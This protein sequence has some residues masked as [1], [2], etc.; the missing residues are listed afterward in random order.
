MENLIQGDCLDNVGRLWGDSIDT[1]ITSPPYDNLR[2]YNDNSV[3]GSDVWVPLIKDLYRVTRPGGVVVWIVADATIKGS[4]SGTSFKQALYA[5]ECGF[6]LHDT[7]IWRKTNPLPLSHNRYEPA[8]EYMFVF[9]KGRPSSVNKLMRATK[10]HGLVT[11][12]TVQKKQDGVRTK[13][14]TRIVNKECPLTNVWDNAVS[15]SV[16]GHP[17]EFPESLV[18]KHILSW[19]NPGDLALDPFMGSGTTG[20]ACKKLGRDFIGIELDPEYFQIASDR[21]KNTIAQ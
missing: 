7:M 20:V 3:W 2:S 9:S 5:K 18:S 1:T 15:A 8:F 12:G 16:T 11:K 4:E 6:N 14:K 19:S 10:N 17:A 21:I 13:K